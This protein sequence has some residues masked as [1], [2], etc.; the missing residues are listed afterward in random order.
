MATINQLLSQLQSDKN[1]LVSNLSIKGVNATNTETFTS[2][3]PKVLEIKTNG[4]TDTS[5]GTAT[6]NDIVKEK[7][8]YVNGE[9]IVGIIDENKSGNN[10]IYDTNDVSLINENN[11]VCFAYKF[12][13]DKLF[14]NGSDIS[15]STLAS[16]VANTAGLTADKIKKGETILGV[17]GTLSGGIDTSDADA[18]SS[19]ILKGKTAYVNGEKIIGTIVSKNANTYIPSTENQIIDSGQYINEEQVI[20]GDINLISEN[21]KSGITIFNVIGSYTGNN[22]GTNETILLDTTNSTSQSDTLM[23]YGEKIYISENNN[24][25]FSSLAEIIKNDGGLLN[26]NNQ[27]ISNNVDNKYGIY[28]GNWADSSTTNS[29]LFTEPIVLSQPHILLVLNC[30]VNS[31]STQTLNIY[32]VETTGNT[33]EEKLESA[34]NNITNNNFA[35]SKTYSY[36]GINTQTDVFTQL[37]ASSTLLGEYFIYISGTQKGNNEFTYIKMGVINF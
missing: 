25:T 18:L 30:N 14:R 37:E 24:I 26:N 11:N 29:I 35:I 2:L 3:I 28:M 13:K 6:A 9:R 36:N 5:D 21:I 32:L 27:Y 20:L 19:D 22:S 34:K 1:D 8:A 23:N 10:I 16:N 31:W 17:T 33:Y 12:N 15:L 7:I 4:G